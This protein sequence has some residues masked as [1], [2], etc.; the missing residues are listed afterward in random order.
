MSL[1][2]AQLRGLRQPDARSCGPSALVAAR[3]LLDGRTVSR[4]EFGARVLAL[5]RD[6]TS[7][8]GAGLPWPRAL[9]T[10]PWGAARR[11]AAWTGT[12]HRTRVNRWRHL[13]PEA[14]GRAEPVL[15]YVGSRWLPRHVLLVAQERVYDPARGTVAPAYDGR[16]RTTWLVVEPTG[17]R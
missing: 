6:V 5:H 4:D 14:C 2:V 10:P 8:A 12:R 1:D 16:W 11:L 7:V 9:G 17:S 3:M 13:S 15:V